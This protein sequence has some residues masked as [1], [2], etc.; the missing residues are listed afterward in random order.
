MTYDAANAH[1]PGPNAPIGWVQENLAVLLS[2]S[3]S[4][5]AP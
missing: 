4:D 1:A 3:A 2:A 5:G